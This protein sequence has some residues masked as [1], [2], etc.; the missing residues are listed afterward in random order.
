MRWDGQKDG[1]APQQALPGLPGLV[2]SVRTPEFAD[3]VFHEVHAKS[4]LN[5]VPGT[6]P[7]PFKWTV[8]PYRGCT[9]G[10]TYCLDGST[11]ILLA[12]GRVRA[13][14]AL[15]VGDEICG[16]RGGRYVRTTVLAHWHTV[17]PAY[18][19]VLEDGT[20]LVSSADHRFLSTSI[21]YYR[22]NPRARAEIGT[23]VG[24]ARLL[25]ALSTAPSAD[26]VRG[27]RSPG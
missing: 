4:V 15:E 2:R 5:K 19:V 10:C 25:T 1:A 14:A 27:P 11:P 6:S 12:D 7:M 3:V 26:A 8:N 18:R 22:D 20:S 17:K 16:T 9:H 24:Y 13:L 21:R 23:D